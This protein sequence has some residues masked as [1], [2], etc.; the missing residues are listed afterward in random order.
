LGRGCR[1]PQLTSLLDHRDDTVRVG[2]DLIVPEPK[3]QPT[4]LR[5]DRVAPFVLVRLVVLPAVGFNRDFEFH[6]REIENE[7]WHRMLAPE[8]P[9]DPMAS[10]SRPQSTFGVRW[11]TACA[12]C[13]FGFEQHVS[14]PLLASPARS[15]GEGI[16]A[17]PYCQVLDGMTIT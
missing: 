17:A 4:A 16:L 9:P 13:H 11:T 10:Q 7:W 6:A 12:A 15:A 5:E 14:C 1:S 2:Q 3:Y 8:V